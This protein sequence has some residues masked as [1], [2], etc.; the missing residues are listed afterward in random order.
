MIVLGIDPGQT[1]GLVLLDRRG[2][3]KAS[4]MPL[5]QKHTKKPALDWMSARQM[6]WLYKDPIYGIIENVHAM[7]A[8]GVASSFQFGRMFGHVEMLAIC[9]CQTVQYVTPQVWKKHFN[10]GRDKNEAV[11]LATELYG[12][13]HWPLKKHEGIAE[14]AL[15]ANWGLYKLEQE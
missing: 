7:P 15:I 9:Y 8:Q 3:L 6:F 4:H 14:A 5:T 12:K 13:K 2:I 10:L 11:A 1:G